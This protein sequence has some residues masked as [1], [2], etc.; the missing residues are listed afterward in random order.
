[1]NRPK[2]HKRPGNGHPGWDVYDW[3][4]KRVA[5]TDCPLAADALVEHLNRQS[6]YLKLFEVRTSERRRYRNHYLIEA[7][8]EADAIQ[9]VNSGEE[10]ADSEF[11]EALSED[12]IEV[13]ERP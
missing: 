9:A 1:M 3:F 10:Y 2:H 5:W 11:D 6:S 13:K 12:V 4:G 7:A 8:N